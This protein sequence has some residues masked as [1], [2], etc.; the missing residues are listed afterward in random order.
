VIEEPQP[1]SSDDAVEAGALDDSDGPQ[2]PPTTEQP[3]EGD[4]ADA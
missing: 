4:D 1:Q 3:A 2:S